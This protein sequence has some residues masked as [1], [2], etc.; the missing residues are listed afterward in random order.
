MKGSLLLFEHISLCNSVVQHCVFCLFDALVLEQRQWHINKH[1][2]KKVCP[3]I[4]K[5]LRSFLPEG[6]LHEVPPLWASVWYKCELADFLRMAK[7]MS[8][9]LLFTVDL[10]W[11]PSLRFNEQ[12]CSCREAFCCGETTRILPEVDHWFAP[13]STYPVIQV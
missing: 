4:C 11:P 10:S 8:P 12:L 13:Y 2:N 7:S 9:Y 5:W 6:A 3:D 1:I